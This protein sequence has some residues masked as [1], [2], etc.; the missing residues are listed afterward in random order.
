MTSDGAWISTVRSIA[1]AD[2]RSAMA[3]DRITRPATTISAMILNTSA[4]SKCL[5][6]S[7]PGLASGL[8]RLHQ[9]AQLA[10]AIARDLQEALDHLE[11]L[12]LRL[13]LEQREADDGITGLRGRSLAHGDL[14]F[15]GAHAGAE[16]A[17]EER[18]GR[19]QHARLRHLVHQ[20]PHLGHVLRARRTGRSV[21]VGCV[22]AQDSH[23]RSPSGLDSL[24]GRTAECGADR[25]SA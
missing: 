4:P 25:V 23:L 11:H 2:G 7:Y 21:R 10:L 6:P 20:L 1:N 13:H 15:G 24:L 5:A 16:G 18:A 17:R 22:Q 14:P 9:H 3:T 8:R 12:R 19:D